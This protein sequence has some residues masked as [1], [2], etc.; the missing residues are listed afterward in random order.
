MDGVD[1]DAW[2]QRIRC[3]TFG[4]YH[5][6]MGIAIENEGNAEAALDAYRRAMDV[7][8]DDSAA[9]CHA[10]ML[11][12]SLGRIQPAR[13]LDEEIRHRNPDY[14][15][16]F[17][18]A[19]VSDATE[20]AAFD[21][22]AKLIERNST[23]FPTLVREQAKLEAKRGEYWF[24]QRQ[25]DTAFTFFERALALDPLQPLANYWLGWRLFERFDALGAVP[26]LE[27]AVA[28]LPDHGWAKCLL[29][30]GRFLLGRFDEAEALLQDGARK[31]PPEQAGWISHHLAIIAFLRGDTA[32]T[33]DRMRLLAI[34]EPSD[35]KPCF[36]RFL[37]EAS[38][39]QWDAAG[40]GLHRFL[41]LFPDFPSMI[42][43]QGLAAFEQNRTEEG[44]G[45][46]LDVEA[47]LRREREVGKAPMGHVEALVLMLA[48]LLLV[49]RG[50]HDEALVH[51]R[52]LAERQ[53]QQ[54]TYIGSLL[55][56]IVPWAAS[57]LMEFHRELGLAP[58]GG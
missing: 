4:N 46:V 39:G 47:R 14:A 22:A 33:L 19:L 3:D 32:A 44:L 57:V 29:G 54:L 27:R 2:R 55:S 50:R 13:A 20:P 53:P 37:A 34:D 51:Y 8:P 38:V 42:A 24:N 18:D 41:V 48:S 9:Y 36:L 10:I 58:L 28:G 35:E 17:F 40:V 49:R 16:D 26:F 25:T 30:Y 21:K 5:L 23:V 1:I 43:L 7:N 12:H 15:A 6:Q 31:T 11:L 56:R 45:Y 52:E